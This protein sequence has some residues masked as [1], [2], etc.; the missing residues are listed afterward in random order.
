MPGDV[1]AA[2][3][4]APAGFVPEAGFVRRAVLRL[5]AI[6]FWERY[7]YYNM[8]TLLALFV[9]APVARGGMG[10]SPGDALRFFG[11][12]LLA[13]QVT[14]LV[15]G[16][17]TDKWLS[18]RW[19]LRLGALGLLLG[20]SMMAGPSLI[21]WACERLTGRPLL[22]TLVQLGA[23]LG[24][25]HIPVGL[26]AGLSTPYLATTASFYG[27]VLLVALGNGLFKPII[28]TVTGRL[29]YASQA[30]RESAFTAFFLFINI[31][32]LVA[33]LFGGWLGD[34]IGW[35][36]AFGAAATGMGIAIVLMVLLGRRYVEPFLVPEA[37]PVA[38]PVPVPADW[39]FLRPI[40]L[41]LVII[42]IFGICSYQ[43]Y[44]F[45]GL[46]TATFVDRNVAG[47]MVPPSWFVSI[48]PIT[49]MAMTPI[50]LGL[51][52]RGGLGHDWSPT[53]KC[54]AGFLLTALGIAMLIGAVIQAE[55]A[56]KASP[57]WIA[58]VMLLIATAELLIVPAVLSAVT[59][60]APA[61]RQPLAVGAYSA[62]TGIGAWLSGEVGA[63]AMEA[64]KLPVL[65][66]IAAVCLAMPVLLL[67]VL[68]RRFAALA[69]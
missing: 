30:E 26:P 65:L 3:S 17:I 48:N 19:A 14:P 53:Q 44:G 46:F 51:W 16:W 37:A 36:W 33:T 18:G 10:W 57:L 31:G 8:F 7:G 54:A 20:H 68:R 38:S 5:S 61:S 63:Q 25:L 60:L 9:A 50:L 13:V 52:R 23:P 35:G 15:G 58:L 56:G 28:T 67:A 66:A 1:T 39:S 6:E 49:I 59:R 43:C 42:V 11:F 34:N 24:Q 45:V 62:A 41:L 12:Y 27:A 40:A 69:I 55:T 4:A 64:G 32:G 22:A 47:F 29:P 2:A 21:P